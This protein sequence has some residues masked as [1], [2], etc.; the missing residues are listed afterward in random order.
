VEGSG[1]GLLSSYY[2]GIR[3][4]GLRTTTIKVSQ[5]SRTPGPDLNPGPLEYEVVVLT[6]LLRRSVP[7]IKDKF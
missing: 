6:T 4:E 2:T 7:G 5:G 1:R 3:L